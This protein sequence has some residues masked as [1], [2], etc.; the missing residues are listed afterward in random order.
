VEATP[1]NDPSRVSELLVS[2]ITSPVQW[3]ASI[4]HWVGAGETL[5]VE[6]GSGRVLA[7]LNRR[8]D[9]ALK[10]MGGTDAASL[11]KVCATLQDR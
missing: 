2:Q 1:N 6:L 8:I 4:Q 3:V 11:E 10:T 5:A 7:G 9:R